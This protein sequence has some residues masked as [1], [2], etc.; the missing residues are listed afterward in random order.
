VRPTAKGFDFMRKTAVP[1]SLNAR[2]VMPGVMPP[3]Q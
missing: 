2:R 1:I 3:R